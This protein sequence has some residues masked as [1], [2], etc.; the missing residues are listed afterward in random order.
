[1]TDTQV[2]QAL[3]LQLRYGGFCPIPLYG[4]E[5]PRYG[6]NNN[7]KGL[8]QWEQLHDVSS[9]QI[10]LWSK[11]WPDAN[12]T[13][14]LCRHMPTLDLDILMQDAVRALVDHVR[15]HYEEGGHIL[16]RIGLPPK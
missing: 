2:A 16:P 13:G 14:C 11:T 8:R 5:P 15:E 10:E 6:K 9:E 7:R 4:K 1:M 3:R 12:N